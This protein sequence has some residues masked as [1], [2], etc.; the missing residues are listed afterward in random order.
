MKT[1][2]K[3]KRV[4]MRGTRYH[5][6][7]AKKHKG[8]GNRGGKG[9]SGS[10]KRADQKK[11]WVIRYRYPYF[12]KQGFTSRKTERDKNKAIQLKDIERNLDSFAEKYGRKTNQGYEI[13][14]SNYKVLG[15]DKISAK[16]ILKVKGISKKAR[17]QVERAGGKIIRK[18]VKG[19]NGV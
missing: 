3:K 17:E 5:G 6:W 4:R 18:E 10:G 2:K 11:T 12:G 16:L 14:L 15:N 9:M 13:N 1:H 8:S 7:A 19:K